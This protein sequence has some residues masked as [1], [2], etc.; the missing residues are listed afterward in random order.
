VAFLHGALFA[1]KAEQERVDALRHSR[2]WFGTYPAA[3]P[4]PIPTGG[5]MT[6]TSLLCRQHRRIEQLLRAL[7]TDGYRRN[8]VLLELLGE[9]TSHLAVEASL[10]YP[11]ARRAT[12]LPLTEEAALHRRMRDT[13]YELTTP[14]TSGESFA[15]K[16]E[17]LSKAFEAH[18]HLDES[19]VYPALV[20]GLDVPALEE[21][22]EDIERLSA[23][24]I[25]RSRPYA[26]SGSAERAA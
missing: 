17:L 18:A 14:G 24:L 26:R 4:A 20:R 15:L 9:L 25:A 3:S 6:A 2:G 22:G 19:A 1:K 13:L 16:A 5:H 7:K 23:A 11:A 10:L 21:L 12:R 8:R